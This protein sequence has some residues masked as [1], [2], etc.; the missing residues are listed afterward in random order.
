MKTR[1]HY[2]V[3]FALYGSALFA[4]MYQKLFMTWQSSTKSLASYGLATHVSMQS[5]HSRTLK[6]L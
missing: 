4:V 5:P 2:N 1:K 6:R 3:N